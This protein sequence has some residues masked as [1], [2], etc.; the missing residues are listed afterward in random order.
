MFF[1]YSLVNKL[2]TG[3]NPGLVLRIKDS[4]MELGHKINSV[5]ITKMTSRNKLKSIRIYRKSGIVYYSFNNEL[6]TKLQDGQNFNEYFDDTLWLGAAKDAD[7]NPYR[8]IRAS[9]SNVVIK[10]S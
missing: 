1:F 2:E 4:N 8:H 9:I 7:G 6:L 5:G 10:T 3:K